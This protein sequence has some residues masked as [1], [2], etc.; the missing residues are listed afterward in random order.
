[1]KPGDTARLKGVGKLYTLIAIDV[2]NKD[3]D[4]ECQWAR[5]T[6]PPPATHIAHWPIEQLEST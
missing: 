2:H 3:T 1:M 6:P 4:Y 5:L